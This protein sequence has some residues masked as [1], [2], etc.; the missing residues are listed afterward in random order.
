[1]IGVRPKTLQFGKVVSKEIEEAISR[2]VKIVKNLLE[3]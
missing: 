3:F 1:L 2:A